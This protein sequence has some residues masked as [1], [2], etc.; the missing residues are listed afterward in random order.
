VLLFWRQDNANFPCRTWPKS[1][2]PH[3]QFLI[4]EIDCSK[5]VTD[6]LI[7]FIKRPSCLYVDSKMKFYCEPASRKARHGYR[8]PK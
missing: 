8:L 2:F 1:V 5:L 7:D 6:K 3:S 4:V